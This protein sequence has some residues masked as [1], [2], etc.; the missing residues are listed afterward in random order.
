MP[1]FE[2]ITLTRG[3]K[4]NPVTISALNDNLSYLPLKQRAVVL[5]SILEESQGNAGAM[6]ENGT[7]QGLLQWGADRYKIKGKGNA[8]LSNQLQYLKNTINNP[9]DLV[10]WT[11]GGKGSGYKSYKDAYN[12]FHNPASPLEA[13]LRGFNYG[14]VRPLGK[15]DSYNNRLKVAQQV[16]DRLSHPDISGQYIAHPD[17]TRVARPMVAIPIHKKE[18]GGYLNSYADGGT[19]EAPKNWDEL[20]LREKSD[21]IMQAVRNDIT[22]LREIR[23]AYNEFAEGGYLDNSNLF[24]KGG[25]KPSQAIKNYISN[26]EGS[27]MKTNRS[28]EAE[29]KDFWNKIPQEVRDNMTQEE[30]DALYSYSYNVGAG[31][32]RKRVVPSLTRLYNG[33]GSVKDVQ[34]SMWA[35]KDSQLRGLAIRRAEERNMFGNAFKGQHEIVDMEDNNSNDNLLSYYTPANISAMSMQPQQPVKPVPVEQPIISEANEYAQ[36]Q[37]SRMNDLKK[38]G[39][40]Y[41]LMNPND[42]GNPYSS[43]ANLLMG[44]TVNNN[45]LSVLKFGDGGRKYTTNRSNLHVNPDGTMTDLSTRQYVHGELPEVSIT[46]KER[47]DIQKGIKNYL[48]LSN[49][50]TLVSNG[51]I[52][53]QHLQ[54][55]ALEGANRHAAWENDHPAL[56]EWSYVPSLAVLGTAMTPIAAGVSDAIVGSSIGNGLSSITGPLV[57]AAMQASKSSWMPWADALGTSLSI[58]DGIRR[59]RNN[60]FSPEAVLEVSPLLRGV[61]RTI[62]IANNLKPQSVRNWAYVSKAPIGYN[63]KKEAL[64]RFIDGITSGKP[65]DIDTPW[66][67]NMQQAK[68]LD[69]YAVY[70]KSLSPTERESYLQ[71]FRENALKAR[72]DMWRMYNH[73]PQKYD[74]FVPSKLHPGAWTSDKAIKDIKYLPPQIEGKEQSDFV[75]TVGGNIGIPDVKHLAWDNGIDGTHREYGVTITDDWFNLHPFSRVGDRVINRYVK[76]MFER[77]VSKPIQ[78]ISGKTIKT[79]EFNFL[80]PL[81]DKIANYEIGKLIGSNPVLVKYDIPWTQEAKFVIDKNGNPTF[82][83]QYVPGFVSDKNLPEAVRNW[84]QYYKLSNLNSNQKISDGITN[85]IKASN[86]FYFYK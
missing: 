22:S 55:R 53:N 68:R 11:D 2:G 46:Q 5:A 58:S 86:F 48:T 44:D 70:P 37:Q 65:A 50:A 8:E 66:W 34:N 13:V 9:S 16:Y 15:E 84:K 54:D 73:I 28:F 10:S 38:L 35:S 31:N 36:K 43:Y 59:M 83:K 75:T 74:T 56:T 20:S 85:L 51:R 18:D 21:I 42:N 77:I 47:H 64:E 30:A 25:Y 14:Y 57:D 62:G 45:P 78:K 12:D 82:M 81:E 72:A 7:Y 49:D 41:S 27:S 39:M 61:P 79:P 3:R 60:Y 71:N 52:Q 19:L 29:A 4:Y 24:L 1:N 33:E 40:I 26:K 76:P 23:Q 63:G 6:S 67:F 17:T 32:F 80:K 69:E